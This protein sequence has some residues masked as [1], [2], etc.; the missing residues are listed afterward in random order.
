MALA[1]CFVGLSHKQLLQVKAW[2]L[3]QLAQKK[4]SP[5]VPVVPVPP[6][7]IYSA[8]AFNDDGGSTDNL[9]RV[10]TSPDALT[11][12]QVSQSYSDTGGSALRDPTII[13]YYGKYWC[14]YTEDGGFY[15]GSAYFGL[16]SS[17]DGIT[18]TKVGDI[19]CFTGSPPS[20]IS[21]EWAPSW[22][23]DPADGS[24]HLILNINDISGVGFFQPY[25]AHPTNS[26]MT[27]WSSAVAITGSTFVSDAKSMIDA[28]MDFKNGTY[29]LWYKNDTD[30]YI[31][32][33]S[34]ASPF[35]GYTK[36]KTGNWA[37]WGHGNISGSNNGYEAPASLNLPNG[38][39][40]VLI[41]SSVSQGMYYSDSVDYVTW[42]ALQ[43]VTT[44]NTGVGPMDQLECRLLTPPV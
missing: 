38:N 37:G 26:A 5:V 24:L 17:P 31:E 4:S 27:T 10:F 25:E 11:F 28:F 22:F 35:S 3:C 34:S 42:P 15:Y 12:T 29:Y 41:D 19:T 18:W 2:L 44:L 9:L 43:L 33:A 13:Y 36:I 6:A 14:A 8:V 1:R 40:R 30:K 21:Y 23:I 39:T 32:L 7:L 20:N 16:A